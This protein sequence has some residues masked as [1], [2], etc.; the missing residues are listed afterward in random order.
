MTDTTAPHFAALLAEA[1]TEPGRIHAAY[2]AFHGYSIGNQL[3]ALMQCAERRI[4]P[5]PIAT[6][7]AWKDR[8]RHVRK[9]EKAI[10]LCMPITCKRQPAD[11]SAEQDAATFTRFIYRPR[12]F[13]LSQTD[14]NEFTAPTLPDWPKDAALAALAI[15]ETPFTAT[16]GNAQ[17]YARARTIAINPVAAL[18]YKTLFHELAH[19]LLGHTAEAEQTDTEQTPRSLREVEAEAVAMLCCA[20]LQLPGI[21]YSR[22]YIQHWN[23]DGQPIPERSA[24][25]IFKTADQILRAGRPAQHDEQEA[26]C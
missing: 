6:F 20:A 1:V 26:G 2:T 21:E 16:D 13:V 17:G 8:G 11:E 25:K 18:P 24:A 4:E 14:G 10:T 7:P 22:G 3:L 9:G 15:T 12:W 23:A 19:V 5:G